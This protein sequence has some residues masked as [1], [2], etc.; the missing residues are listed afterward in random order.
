MLKDIA[1][2]PGDIIAVEHLELFHDLDLAA[3]ALDIMAILHF[4]WWLR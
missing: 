3:A 4:F 2:M 1:A